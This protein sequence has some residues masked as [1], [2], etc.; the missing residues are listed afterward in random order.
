MGVDRIVSVTPATNYNLVDIGTL[1]T[2][3]GLS[4]TMD[5]AYLA[6]LVTQASAAVANYCN[7]NLVV[8]TVAET[9]WPVHESTW[10]IVRGGV[11]PLQLT[12]WPLVSVTS[13]VETIMGT[14]TT[15]TQNTDY[16]VD[17][18][19][20]QLVRLDVNGYPCRWK[21]N[22][23]AVN[24]SA[25]FSTIPS[26]VI[27]ATT[28]LVKAAYFAQ[29]RDPNLRSEAVQG[30]AQVTYFGQRTG[31]Q[32]GSL[33]ADVQALLSSYRQPVLASVA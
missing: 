13:V 2:M 10:G 29:E 32:S 17:A 5:D 27:D 16:L 11:A 22:Q 23:I 30:I 33:P 28:R 9:V 20:G 12:N 3:L 26:D 24:Y 19:K 18:K 14:A 6:L 8:E 4:G 15:L 1:K 31:A 21:P 25:G 7:R